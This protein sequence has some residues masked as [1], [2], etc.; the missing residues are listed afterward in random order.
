MPKTQVGAVQLHYLTVGRGPDVVMVHGFL[1]N[2][3]VWHLKIIPALYN[4]FR[5]TTYDLRGHGF[6]DVTNAGYTSGN[7]AEDL[8][9]LLDNLDIPQV[10]LVGHSFGADVCLHFALRYPERVSKMVVIE[11]G[12]AAAMQQRKGA[13][14]GRLGV[15]GVEA[16][17]G[18]TACAGRQAHRSAIPARPQPADAAFLRA[19]ERTAAKSGAAAASPPCDQSDQRQPGGG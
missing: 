3:A 1:G 12:L 13:D 6:S 18:G 8:R 5:I 14:C 16:R 2:L 17:T 4:E 11:P 7:L 9:G 19:A 10:A 15:L